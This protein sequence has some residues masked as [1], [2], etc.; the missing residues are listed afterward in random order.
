MSKKRENLKILPISCGINKAAN[1]RANSTNY[2]ARTI[3]YSAALYVTNQD[4]SEMAG[5]FMGD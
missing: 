1:Y 5:F 3:N 2:I 4:P